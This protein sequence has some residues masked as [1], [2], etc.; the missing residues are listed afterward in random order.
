[1][2]AEPARG[3]QYGPGQVP[4]KCPIHQSILLL[5]RQC[6]PSVPIIPNF[7]P[8]RKWVMDLM[9]AGL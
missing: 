9:P 1:M 8:I 4:D 3:T 7:G 6:G 5:V 2:D